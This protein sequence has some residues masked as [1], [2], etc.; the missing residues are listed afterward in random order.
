MPDTPLRSRQLPHQRSDLVIR[1]H[2]VAL[3]RALHILRPWCRE[4]AGG[5][6][7]IELLRIGSQHIARTLGRRTVPRRLA[8]HETHALQQQECR[9]HLRQLIPLATRALQQCAIP[10]LVQVVG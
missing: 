6:R 9:A 5:D 4:F 7:I 2:P 3:E 1:Q 8:R 10:F